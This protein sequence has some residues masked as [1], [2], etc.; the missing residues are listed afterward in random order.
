[1]LVTK[2]QRYRPHRMEI[3]VLEIERETAFPFEIN[4]SLHISVRIFPELLHNEE[5]Q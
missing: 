4:L 5:I 1:M 3:K 2:R